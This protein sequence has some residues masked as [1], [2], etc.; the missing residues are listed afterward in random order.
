MQKEKFTFKDWCNGQFCMGTSSLIYNN[1]LPKNIKQV[2]WTDLS[3][4]E[5]DKIKIKQKEIFDSVKNESLE[6]FIKVYQQQFEKSA[7]R[8]LLHHRE[9]SQVNQILFR[10]FAPTEEVA[11]SDHWNILFVNFQLQHLQNYINE[12]IV[13]GNPIDYS[14]IHHPNFLYQEKKH[15]PIPVYAQALWEYHQW[16]KNN[17]FENEQNSICHPNLFKN[18]GEQ[19]FFALLPQIVEKETPTAGFSALF[20]LLKDDDLIYPNVKP[21]DIIELA[22]RM[23]YRIKGQIFKRRISRKAKNIYNGYVRIENK[24]LP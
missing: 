10:K 13:K 24:L 14:F 15:P 9:L 12:H 5:A 4:K 19:K 22:T 21:K 20:F 2:K 3:P 6:N 23:G 7:D 11:I 16:L 1:K 18:G 17:E 8:K